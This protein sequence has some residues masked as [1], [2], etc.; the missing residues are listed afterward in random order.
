[1]TDVRKHDN[2]VARRWR[3][4]RK[5][6]AHWTGPTPEECK[7]FRLFTN[8]EKIHLLANAAGTPALPMPQEKILSSMSVIEKYKQV[9]MFE[10]IVASAETGTDKSHDNM[11]EQCEIDD[12][13][14]RKVLKEILDS[15]R[16]NG[17]GCISHYFLGHNQHRTD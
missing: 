3:K 2:Q 17:I 16:K 9:G 1:M 4:L 12:M 15:H 11:K 5:I 7:E 14:N 6:L 8:P 10:A 13:K